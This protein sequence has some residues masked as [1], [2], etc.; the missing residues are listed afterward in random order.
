MTVVMSDDEFGDLV[1]D[2][3]DT[4]PSELTAAMSNVVILVEPAHPDEPG[5]LGLYSG[6]ALTERN[7]EYAGFLPDTIT[8]YRDPILRM[9]ETR[10]QVVHEVAVTVIHE[11][12]HH[13]GIDDAWL[14]THGW[15]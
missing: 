11:I 12:A 1:S 10:D 8:I 9:C 6:V 4:V 2:A 3:L 15:G 14:H 13:F 5:I 7:H